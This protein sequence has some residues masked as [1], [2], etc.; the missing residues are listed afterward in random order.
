MDRCNSTLSAQT[1]TRYLERL[2]L[3][4]AAV[5]LSPAGDRKSVV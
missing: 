5:E 3:F 2:G 4:A 1:V